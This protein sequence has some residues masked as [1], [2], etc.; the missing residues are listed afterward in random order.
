MFDSKL[1]NICAQIPLLAKTTQITPITGGLTNINYRVDTPNGTYM[2]RVSDKSSELLGINRENEK[3]NNEKAHQ[4][5]IAPA[6]KGFL[7]SEN[8]LLIDWIEGKTLKVVDFQ[9]QQDILPRIAETIKTLHRSTSFQGDFN[10]PDIRKQYLK[11][12]LENGYF[13][14][15]G[16]LEVEPLLIE[17]E[18]KL[19]AEPEEWVSCHNDLV[20]ANFIDDGEKIWLIDFEYAS[21]NEPSFDIGNFAAETGLNDAQLTLFCDIYWGEH[22][23]SKIARARACSIITRALWVLWSCIQDAVSPIDYGFKDWAILRWQ[24]V[25][26]DLNKRATN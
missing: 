21:F 1:K 7:P 16:V 15:E 11:I 9:T 14:P 24:T 17:L 19:A 26:N 4:A 12:I 20:A 3:I 18:N 22:R 10:F 23:P 13:M 25:I 2:M 8:V 6:V 5:G